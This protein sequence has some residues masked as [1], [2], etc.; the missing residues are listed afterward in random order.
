MCLKHRGCV[1]GLNIVN[2]LDWKSQSTFSNISTEKSGNSRISLFF[3]FGHILIKYNF[4][5]A[6]PGHICSNPP[7][8]IFFF[9]VECYLKINGLG[10]RK[11]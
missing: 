7:I 4:Y 6:L 5:P 11:P 1:K 8:F 3:V 2:H 10:I 9:D